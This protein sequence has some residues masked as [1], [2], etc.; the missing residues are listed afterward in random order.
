MFGDL[1]RVYDRSRTVIRELWRDG[2]GWILVTVALG[3]SFALGSRLVFPALLPQLKVEFALDNTVAGS[4]IAVLWV[5]YA[6]AQVPGGLLGDRFGERA[7]LVTSL[8]LAVFGLF[9]LLA[10]GSTLAFLVGILVLGFGT[11]L[12]GTT[13]ITVL[14]DV[15]PD[16][17]GTAIGFSSAAG[18]V[19]S[20]GLPVVA[21]VLAAL[22]GWRA[23]IG[24]LVPPFVALSVALWFVVPRR[25]SAAPEAGNQ[26]SLPDLRRFLAVMF[27]R[28]VLVSTGGMIL[29]TSVYQGFTAFFPTYLVEVKG[30][31]QSTAATLLGA[32]FAVGVVLQAVISGI[33]DQYGERTTLAAAA[34][35]TSLA[36]LGLPVL[37]SPWELGVVTIIASLQL[38]FWPVIYAYSVRSLPDDIQGGTFGLQRAVFIIIGAASP[39]AIGAFADAGLFDAGFLFLGGIAA[40]AGGLAMALPALE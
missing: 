37:G 7:I 17:R 25:T 26:T 1:S 31:S 5:A 40:L 32:F 8:L 39:V 6:A 33:A 36:M 28:P 2:D 30:I 11:G 3:W 9:V 10:T 4:V 35:L 19:G 16:W 14:A 15:Y 23:G 12:F 38:A 34:C 29:M 22:Y 21:G 20:A 13:R 27:R 18:N 24:V